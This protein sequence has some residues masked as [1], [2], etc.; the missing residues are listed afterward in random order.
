MRLYAV[1]DLHL[2]H[3]ENRRALARIAARPD[4]WLILAG[5]TGETIA[6]LELAL[7]VLTP[8]FRQIVWTPGNHDLWTLP[9]EVRG[10]CGRDKYDQLVQL[11]RSFGVLTPEDP[12]AIARFGGRRIRIAPL[13]L[14]YATVFDR[15]NFPLSAPSTGRARPTSNA[16]TSTF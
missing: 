8:R 13:F 2:G 9:G 14:L 15:P 6:H 4:D 1:S 7:R 10:R 5:D 11:C 16:P 3:E 12:Y